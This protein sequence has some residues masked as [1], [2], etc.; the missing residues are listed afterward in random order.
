M[1]GVRGVRRL[2]CQ[3]E[4][5]AAPS[6]RDRVRAA[7]GPA[8]H[9]LSDTRGVRRLLS[10]VELIG[11]WSEDRSQLLHRVIVRQPWRARSAA[12]R[13]AA[14]PARR[15]VAGRATPAAAARR[16]DPPQ[17]RLV[18]PRRHVVGRVL[19]R[20]IH[21]A[22][23]R[24]R[25][26]RGSSRRTPGSPPAVTRTASRLA[27]GPRPVDLDPP[28][29]ARSDVCYEAAGPFPAGGAV[30]D[31]VAGFAAPPAPAV[32]TISTISSAAA[33]DLIPI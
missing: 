27:S 17:R 19:A 7:S 33:A 18:G 20:M 25:A 13:G 9:G 4:K 30:V 29:P 22:V 16:G 31:S 23:E 10:Y 26:A 32:A 5:R 24:D 6:P 11:G 15:S 3:R 2:L 28:C 12:A 14:R 21:H 1:S 8:R